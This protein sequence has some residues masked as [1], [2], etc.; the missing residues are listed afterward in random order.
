MLIDLELQRDYRSGRDAL[1]DDFYIPCLQEAVTYDRA[2]GFF[3]SSLLHVV[4][5]AYSD[6]V[7]RR[8]HMRLICSPALQPADFEAMKAGRSL[9]QR[10]QELVR[11]E[12]DA[13]LNNPQTVPAT[14]LLASL[15]AL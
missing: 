10:A 3:S 4:A 11:A 9:S 6:F 7:R 14:R 13:L 12:L 2:V 8:G 5:V 1:L 15:V